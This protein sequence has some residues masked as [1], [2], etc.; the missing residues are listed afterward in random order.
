[1]PPAIRDVVGI[2]RLNDLKNAHQ[3]VAIEMAFKHD[4]FIE[5]LPQANAVI[6][7]HTFRFPEYFFNNN[8]KLRWVQSITVGLD[9][10]LT[11]E[12]IAAGHL[13]I[14]TCRGPFGS[15]VARHATM[16]MLALARDLPEY[17]QSQAK[18]QWRPRATG[19][20]PNILQLFGKTV[21]ILGVGDIGGHLARICKVGF[22]VKVLGTARRSR[23]NPHVDRYF[24]LSERNANLA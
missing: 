9:A 20:V 13:T 24:D 19:G 17:L 16:L 10:F 5:L 1:M 4:K 23:D 2:E 7:H 14:T 11:P 18:H 6:T 22:G 8:P 21:A 12:M 3:D 15:L